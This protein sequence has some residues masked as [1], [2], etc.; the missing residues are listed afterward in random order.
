M[1]CFQLSNEQKAFHAISPHNP[2][3]GK[4][5][6]LK[7]RWKKLATIL[8]VAIENNSNADTERAA[9]RSVTRPYSGDLTTNG[10]L[11]ARVRMLSHQ[12][13]ALFEKGEEGWKV[14]PC[15][16]VFVTGPC[17]IQLFSLSATLPAFGPGCEFS[18]PAPAP[19]VLP[20][21]P[22]WWQRLSLWNCKWAP[23]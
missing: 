13:M 20:H 23:N 7:C 12:S 17:Q 15:W 22:P 14:W 11:W 8:S 6:K 18:A 3:S 1:I 16:K 2:S 10:A 4:S 21:P 9:Q 19:R 5:K